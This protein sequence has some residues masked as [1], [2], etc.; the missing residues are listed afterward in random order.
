MREC[1]RALYKLNKTDVNGQRKVRGWN[2]VMIMSITIE[3]KRKDLVPSDA[4]TTQFCTFNFWRVGCSVSTLVLHLVRRVRCNTFGCRFCWFYSI[5]DIC[6]TQSCWTM[7]SFGGIWNPTPPVCLLLTFSWQ[8]VRC[9]T[10]SCYANVHL[11][12][13]NPQERWA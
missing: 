5:P 10:Y 3:L 11:L 9:F 2:K 13:E 7:I 4:Q 12:H 8:C 6:A 1:C